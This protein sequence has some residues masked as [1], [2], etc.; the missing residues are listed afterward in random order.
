MVHRAETPVGGGGPERLHTRMVHRLADARERQDAGGPPLLPPAVDLRDRALDVRAGDGE[1]RLEPARM[2]GGEVVHHA[3]V[4][5]YQPHLQRGIA[6]QR[7]TD[8]HV[9]HHHVHVR[10]FLVHVGDAL[11]ERVVDDADTGELLAGVLAE[12]EAGVR[13]LR[14]LARLGVAQVAPV[15]A[16]A[17]RVVVARG[18][19][20]RGGRL[21]GARSDLVL[22]Q[23]RQPLPEL[24]V[25][26]GLQRLHRRVDV[27]VCV[28]DS[29]S[30]QHLRPP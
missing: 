14:G 7:D 3:V 20:A 10:A 4:G 8:G 11:L 1:E 12:V 22:L 29:L 24:A 17:H 16:E 23:F 2:R 25:E 6:E 27:R 5:A 15:G 18:V 13:V 9:R 30:V 19:F 26:V 21:V 28:E